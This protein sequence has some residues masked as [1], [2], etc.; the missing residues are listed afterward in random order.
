MKRHRIL[1]VDDDLL[2]LK[3]IALS[4]KNRGYEVITASNGKDAIDILTERPPDLVITDLVME[5][6]GGIDVLKKAK[7]I[8]NEIMVIIS[9]SISKLQV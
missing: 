5:G 8:D 2:I 4:L 3:A 9:L 7:E 6:T 1:L